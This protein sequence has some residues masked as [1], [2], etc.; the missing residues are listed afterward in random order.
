[1]NTVTSPNTD[2]RTGAGAARGS[3]GPIG[4]WMVAREEIR[5]DGWTWP[6][7]NLEPSTRGG[8]VAGTLLPA[9]FLIY[10]T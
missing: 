8:R 3:A 10:L 1:V 5:R 6:E 4:R 7:D 9:L 2:T